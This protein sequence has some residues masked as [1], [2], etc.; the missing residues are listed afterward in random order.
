MSISRQKGTRFLAEK[1][2]RR[3]LNTVHDQKPPFEMAEVKPPMFPGSRIR[4]PSITGRWRDG[5][6]LNTA[7]IAKAIT[8]CAAAGGGRVVVPQGVWLTGAIHLKSNVDLH[9]AAG[10]NCGS[11]PTR[12]TTC[13]PVFVRW[14]GF[15]CHNY[16]PLIYAKAARTSPSPAKESSKAR[17]VRGGPG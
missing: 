16:S 17:A 4:H 1:V 12:T 8:A 7:A 6:T 15:E 11:A 10:P 2:A 14:A 3:I 13:P 5:K 9:L